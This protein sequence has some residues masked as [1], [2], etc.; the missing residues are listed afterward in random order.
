MP[1]KTLKKPVLKKH[2]YY[3]SSFSAAPTPQNS[4][5]FKIHFRNE[6]QDTSVYYSLLFPL[7]TWNRSS[8][9]LQQE[10]K[11]VNLFWLISYF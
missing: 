3:L 2:T 4:S 6:A 1:M 5:E 11:S 9:Q 10:N 8:Y 7:W